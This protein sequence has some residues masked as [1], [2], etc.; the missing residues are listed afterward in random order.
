MAGS[1]VRQA[2]LPGGVVLHYQ[3]AG[4]GVP[5]VF[6]HGLTG[7]L[8]SWGEQ[9]AAF[10]TR[11]RT[12]TYSRRFSRPNAND[13][14]ALPAHSVRV[15]AA[16]LAQLLEHVA[17]VPAILVGSSFG[18]YTALALALDRPEMVRAMVLSE[19]AV[20][21][22]ADRVAGGAALREQFER[23]AVL[24]ARAALRAGDDE[25]VSRLY[26][27]TVLGEGGID[28][29]P[30]G[31]RERRLANV[32]AIKALVR[33]ELEFVDLDA[34]RAAGL[35]VPTLLLSGVKTAPIFSAIFEAVRQL[36][37][38]VRAF[39]VEGSG[40]SIPRE[41][42]RAFNAHCLRFLDEVIGTTAGSA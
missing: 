17:A 37:P 28:R 38:D 16:D 21:P 5:V 4:T 27:H 33:S 31:P 30:S 20:V 9:V 3:Q 13:P 24:P 18:A 36:L 26:A 14:A 1:D 7:D 19:P 40:H 23:A 29:L 12:I 6:I 2:R 39:K 8:G 41:Q 22:W 15:D 11:Y 10:A 25:E 42:P 34:A 32:A 35:K